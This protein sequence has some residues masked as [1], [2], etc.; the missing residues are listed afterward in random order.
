MLAVGTRLQD[1]TTGSWALFQNAAKT[2]HRLNMQLFDATKHGARPLVWPTP[3]SGLKCSSPT[4]GAD[5]RARRWVERRRTATAN[6]W[7]RRR[8][9]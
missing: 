1:F 8:A 7:R 4:L 9:Q 5:W 3:R 2:Y 6:G